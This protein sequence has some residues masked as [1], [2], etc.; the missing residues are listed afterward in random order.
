MNLKGILN[1]FKIACVFKAVRQNEI[2]ILRKNEFV[3]I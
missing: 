2:S 1:L 3:L